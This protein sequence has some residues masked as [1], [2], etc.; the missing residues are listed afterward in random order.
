MRNFLIAA[1]GAAALALG[2]C[3]GDEA[4]TSNAANDAASEADPALPEAN[5]GTSGGTAVAA[6]DA[7][8]EGN[9]GGVDGNA[10]ID[11]QPP[12][13]GTATAPTDRDGGMHGGTDNASVQQSGGTPLSDED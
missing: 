12:N 4:E 6:P 8:V 1:S 2:G 13:T 9:G 11:S 3:G 7:D 5:A 10:S